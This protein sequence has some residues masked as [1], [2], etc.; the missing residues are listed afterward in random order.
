MNQQGLNIILTGN[1]KGKTTSALGMII[2]AL[3]QNQRVCLIQFIKSPDSE[4]GEKRIL[5]QLGVENHQMGA[6]LTWRTDKQSTLESSKKAWQL[7]KEKIT[8]KQ[9]DL[10][11]LDEVNHLFNFSKT[12]GEELITPDEMIILM[13][14]KP[15]SLNLVLT[16]RYAPQSIMDVAD[17][18]SDVQCV[19]HH[20][21]QG[22]VATRGV[23][24]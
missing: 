2:R 7:A 20:F 18:V 6:G 14:N 4:Y 17:T 3:G 9:Y 19:K 15:A 10:I 22:V 23:E 8:S 24:Y 11:V 1:G 16:G 21:Q 5:D 13:K 12:I